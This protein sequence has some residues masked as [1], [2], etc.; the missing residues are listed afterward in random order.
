MPRQIIQCL[1]CGRV[2]QPDDTWSNEEIS[3][4]QKNI[5][6]TYCSQCIQTLQEKLM[7]ARDFK[8]WGFQKRIKYLSNELDK[9][10][11]KHDQLSFKNYMDEFFCITED[12]Y[13]KYYE[14]LKDKLVPAVCP[15]CREEI[16]SNDKAF[17]IGAHILHQH[18]HKKI[19]SKIQIILDNRWEKSDKIDAYFDLLRIE[20]EIR[21]AIKEL[22]SNK[23]DKTKAIA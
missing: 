14:A 17:H 20:K 21:P 8:K 22:L 1:S 4:F 18:C 10:Q 11:K 19:T 2:K 5:S 3:P 9:H 15:K 23:K 7:A 6:H 13:V 16:K 12:E